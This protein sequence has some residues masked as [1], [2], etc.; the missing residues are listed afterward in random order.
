MKAKCKAFDE[1]VNKVLGKAYNP[2][3]F[4]DNPD[5][6]DMDT[7]TYDMYEDNDKGAYSQVPDIDDVSPDTYNCYVGT[8]VELSIGDKVMSGKVKRRKR[9]HDGSLKGTEHPNPI[10][11]THTYEV[12][13]PD[14]QVA[15]YSANVI[16]ENMYTQCD[17]EGN[18]YLLLDE[19]I[20]WKRT[21]VPLSQ[22][23]TCMSI[24]ITT[25]NNI[26]RP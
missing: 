25:I 1:N 23:M 8:E 9:E 17:A 22:G 18:Q 7:P 19:I 12:E 10:L 3:D 14:R 5:M 26:V 16:A 6:S 4:K 21:I 15:E 2:D 24:L 20:D 11:D 13:F